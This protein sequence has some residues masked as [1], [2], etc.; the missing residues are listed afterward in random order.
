MADFGVEVFS[1]SVACS[2]GT[3]FTM[4]LSVPN[5]GGFASSRSIESLAP[6]A[7]SRA[8]PLRA[9]ASLMENS[10]VLANLTTSDVEVVYQAT[11]VRLDELQDL[12]PV[13]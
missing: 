5:L 12:P 6:A 4:G 9:N 3:D 10:P 2:E 7:T 13:R 8:Q 1:A 11:G